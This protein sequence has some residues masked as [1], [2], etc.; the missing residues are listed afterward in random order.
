MAD[1][2]AKD[3]ALKTVWDSSQAFYNNAKAYHEISEKAYYN[4]R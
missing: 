1:E 2:L 3:P 4:H